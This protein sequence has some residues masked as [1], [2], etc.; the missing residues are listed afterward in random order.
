M[1]QVRKPTM[2]KYL[3]LSLVLLLT[4]CGGSNSPSP[5]PQPPDITAPVITLSGTNPQILAV[6]DAY[7]E[8]G[9]TARDN[10]DGDLTA[11]IVIDT[12]PVNNSA[13]GEYIVTYDVRDAAG[14]AASTVTRSVIYEDRTPPE[15]TLLGE[16]PQLIILGSPYVE[17]GASAHDN[18]DGDLTDKIIIDSGD[19]VVSEVG[20]YVV[21]YDVG[22]SA[23]NNATTEARTVSI[24]PPGAAK[25]NVTPAAALLTALGDT[26]ALN[27]V[28]LDA[29]GNIISNPE[30]AWSS[31]A[32]NVA[33]VIDGVVTANSNGAATISASIGDLS[34]SAV[35][36]VE[37]AVSS[38]EVMPESNRILG[39]DVSYQLEVEVN[40]ANGNAVPFDYGDI[41]W[42][43]SDKGVG[44]VDNNGLVT[45]VAEG[46]VEIVAEIDGI[47]GSSTVDVVEVVFREVD[48]YLAENPGGE[49]M[50]VV[51][52]RY[53]PTADGVN[54]D[55]SKVPD[56]WSL[57]EV[58]LEG[59][60]NRIDVFN[61]RIKFARVEGSRF[62][63]YTSGSAD[64]YLGYQIVA[65][66]IVY[67]HTPPGKVIGTSPA[68]QAVY[69]IDHHAVFERLNIAHYV[70]VMGVREIW[71]WQSH[72]D[73]GF[74]SYDANIHDPADFRGL[75]ESNM[76]SSLTG[77]I[78]NSDRDPS[79]LPIYDHTYIVYGYNMRRSHAEA[80]HNHG[81]QLEAMFSYAAWLQDGNSDLFW[82]Q[83]VGQDPQGNFVTGRAGWTH[84]PPNTTGHYDYLNNTLVESDIEDWTPDNS[85][86]KKLINA[87]TWANLEY[88]WPDGRVD[89]LNGNV[90]PEDA[91]WQQTESQWYIYWMQS[92][93]GFNNEIKYFGDLEMQNWWELVAD[94]DSAI[95]EQRGLHE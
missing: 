86:E 80:I 11:S 44:E 12:S 54:L 77:D 81:H 9:A 33:S 94:W 57:G 72:F 87:F 19:V 78:S 13:P 85:G 62:R 48:P 61:R 2:P 3:S 71:I 36:E 37:Q 16:N 24:L 79:D 69:L 84:M 46:Q 45:T 91:I 47:Q 6:G 89:E 10:R 7:I 23:G 56:F 59:M 39:A 25:V 20:D 43:S 76:S 75:W 53:L 55:I 88:A 95:S 31:S 58:S 27:A 63:D 26:V 67:A 38:V 50:P 35:V 90:E 66:I 5:M 64:N 14:N 52:I 68:G 8:L 17:L 51:I 73:D 18:V 74:P 41:S 49:A 93:P 42:S 30:L 4:A 40:D 1:S 65:D 28:A 34:A 83:F 29:A 92:M 82:K 32:T 21:R 15:I 22:D 60:H 70:N